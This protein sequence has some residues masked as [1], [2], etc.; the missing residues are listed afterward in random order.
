VAIVD[1]KGTRWGSFN[2]SA[3][4]LAGSE[5]LPIKKLRPGAK[6]SGKVVIS[7]PKNAKLKTIRFESGVMGPPLAVRVTK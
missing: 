7:V 4:G 6:V 1:A 5:Q 3:M 2:R